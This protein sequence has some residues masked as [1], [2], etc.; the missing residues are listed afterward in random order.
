MEFIYAQLDSDAMRSRMCVCMR[1][2]VLDFCVFTSLNVS[3]LSSN[4]SFEKKNLLQKAFS[5][6]F[7]LGGC[8]ASISHTVCNPLITL[9]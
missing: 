5:L 4:Q 9:I 7:F 2:C 1:A 8:E 3:L 6:Y